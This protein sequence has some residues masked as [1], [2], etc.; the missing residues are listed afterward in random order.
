M[1]NKIIMAGLLLASFIAKGETIENMAS[2][3]EAIEKWNNGKTVFTL[4]PGGGPDNSAAVRISSDKATLQQLANYCF[5]G[6]SLG[7]KKITVTCDVKAEDIAK[8]EK[9]YMGVKFQL[10]TIAAD[11]KVNYYEQLPPNYRFGDYGWKGAKVMA[12]IPDDAQKVFL[13][14]GLHNTV[15]SV[16]YANI[17]CKI[18]D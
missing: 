6:S 15:G 7:G 16:F 2:S 14:I 10:M 17:T 5:R 12:K 13:V 8:P 4:L 1:K 9:A 11:G 18:E 3:P